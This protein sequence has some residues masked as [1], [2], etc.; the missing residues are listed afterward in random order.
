MGRDTHIL[1]VRVGDVH[2]DIAGLGLR[3]ADDGL[4]KLQGQGHVQT[5]AE[6][7]WAALG[8]RTRVRHRDAVCRVGGCGCVSIGKTEGEK[9]SCTKPRG[10]NC[11]QQQRQWRAQRQ[12]QAQ[13]S[14][15]W[16]RLRVGWVA[17]KNCSGQTITQEQRSW[18][19]KFAPQAAERG[20]GRGRGRVR[21]LEAVGTTV[22]FVDDESPAVQ[23]IP[24]SCA[25]YLEG[26]EGGRGVGAR[27]SAS[28]CRVGRARAGVSTNNRTEP[29]PSS[30]SKPGSCCCHLVV[31][32]R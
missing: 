3:G 12:P 26:G 19:G 20:G 15:A 13:A 10:T 32:W 17:G 18:E 14:A 16:R 21:S 6:G 8:V 27:G 7:Q 2:N 28:S 5:L 4:V 11:Q 29:R 22:V 1:R 24:Q 23:S 30:N 25:T 31:A 9:E